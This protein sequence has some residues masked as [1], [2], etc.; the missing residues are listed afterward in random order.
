MES[1]EGKGTTDQQPVCHCWGH[2]SA[3]VNYL[4]QQIRCRDP[5]IDLLLSL[6]GERTHLTPAS[7]FL[8]GH[9]A[10]GKTY[11][12]SMILSTLQLPAVSV[13]CVECYS[14]RFLFEYILNNLPGRD[15]AAVS[16]TC[17]NMND[18]VRLLKQGVSSQNLQDQTLYIVLDRAERL[19][20]MDINIL[21]ALLRMQELTGL[22]ICTLFLSEI[23]WEKFQYGTAFCDPVVVYMPDYTQE[24]LMQIMLL[25]C[26]SSQ[27]EDLYR[28]YVSLFLSVFYRVC[29]DL[30]EL[31]HMAL[32]NFPKYTEPVEKGEAS[33]KDMRKLWRNIE[34][35]LKKAL[36]TVYLREVSSAQW[37][38]MQR[39]QVSEDEAGPATATPFPPVDQSRFPPGTR[40]PAANTLPLHVTGRLLL[41]AGVPRLI[42]G[43]A[44]TIGNI[45]PGGTPALAT[46][47]GATHPRTPGV[48]HAHATTPH[49]IPAD[50]AVRSEELVGPCLSASLLSGKLDKY[51]LP[52]T[53]CPSLRLSIPVELPYYSKYL[54]VA[55]YLASY[56]PVVSDKRFFCKNAG[57]ISRRSK[58]IKKHERASNH[59][60][61]PKP[62]PMD[63]LLAIFY[64]IIE[65]KIAPSACIFS[66]ITSLVSL[67]LLGQTCADSQIDMPRYKC[68]VS[69]D[70]IRSVARTIG[71]DVMKYLYDFI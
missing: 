35:H 44:P 70:F 50:D 69:L 54:L 2:D 40:A 13:N 46:L 32:L 22:N 39:S 1:M 51:R 26:P 56:N 11:M 45:A 9:T 57:K 68:L 53:F 24:E 41:E 19:R 12:V 29:R 20:E 25:D 66:Q 37:E 36:Q 15:D 7:I 47:P 14:S 17:D 65:D 23:V 18:F 55:A 67:H 5:Q 59:L 3:L 21:P 71:F 64:S 42:T 4:R 31:R 49:A 63:R 48:P 8:Y 30:R 58:L 6:F 28:N 10:T 60:L 16:V 61:G 34:P 52:G 62:F 33:E 38:E 27:S 43:A